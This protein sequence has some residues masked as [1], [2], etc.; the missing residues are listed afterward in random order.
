[1][2]KLEKQT[3][4][5]DDEWKLLERPTDGQCHMQE[6]YALMSDQQIA[7]PF[8]FD[9]TKLPSETVDS[10]AEHSSCFA[11]MMQS[12]AVFKT[13]VNLSAERK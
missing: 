6:P 1:M 7:G 12:M 10:K 5:I 9:L 13:S 3:A 8:L 11:T 4:V 2:F